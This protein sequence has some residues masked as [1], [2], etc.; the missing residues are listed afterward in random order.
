MANDDQNIDD[1]EPD[2]DQSGG[3]DEFGTQQ[4]KPSLGRTITGSPVL[5]IALVG[6]AVLVVVVAITL[7][8]GD[9]GKDLPGAQV[10]SGA[11]ELKE[12]PGT[13]EVT[14]AMRSALEESNQQDLENALKEGTSAVPTP[15]DPPKVLLGV[16]SEETS[17]EDPLVRWK[18]LQEER[19]RL[20]REQEQFNA[21]AQ[22]DPQKEQRVSGLR[23]AMINQVNNIM[24]QKTIGEMQN[25]TVYHMADLEKKA[26]D[27]AAAG[28]VLASATPGTQNG[29]NGVVDAK[30][31]KVVIPAGE[32]VYSQL[33]IEA[34]SD[35][36]GPIVGMIVS[37]PFNGSRVLGKFQRKDEYIVMEFTTLVGKDGHSIPIEAV[38]VDPE[39]T[40]SGMATDVDHRYLQRIVL[41]AATSFIE[42]MGNAIA[43][44]GSTT[45]TVNGGDATV[46]Q[47]ENDLDTEQE[48]SKATAEA[49]NKV[50][51]ILDDEADVEILVRVKAGTPMGLLFTRPVT[52][53][54]IEASRF[55]NRQM[56]NAENGQMQPY[57]L[58][59]QQGQGQQPLFGFVPQGAPGYNSLQS[60]Q[61][62]L[63]NQTALQQ[64]PGGLF[65]QGNQ[66]PGQAGTY[67]V[68]STSPSTTIDTSATSE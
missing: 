64:Q 31:L 51:E 2:F 58:Y 37:G 35:I 38:A 43:E 7:F 49:A 61:Q 5:K 39:T 27:A 20:Q 59:G 12:A 8:G 3:F 44:N 62:G 21:Q 65:Y 45:V 40:L 48:L 23:D 11:Q 6:V 41:P 68:S 33:L 67:P 34:N 53:R 29:V 22:A 30:P 28:V 15:I 4:G 9:K 16:S 42:G 47:E 24:G 52:D 13:K 32:V 36:P 17:G 63:N 46:S 66:M 57:G 10:D 25:I 54:D 56:Q 18:K 19:V 50:G 55:E 26:T 1:F 60:L 14:P